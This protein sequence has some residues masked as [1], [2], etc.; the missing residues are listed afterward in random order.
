MYTNRQRRPAAARVAAATRCPR[1]HSRGFGC[2]PLKAPSAHGASALPA[3]PS[4]RRPEGVQQ[5]QEVGAVR[6]AHRPRGH[7]P[8][9]G[10]APPEEEEAEDAAA[11]RGEEHDAVPEGAREAQRGRPPAK[12]GAVGRHLLLAVEGDRV[13]PRSS[14]GPAADGDLVAEPRVPQPQRGHVLLVDAQDAVADGCRHLGERQGVRRLLDLRRRQ[15]QRV[16]D[17]VVAESLLPGRRLALVARRLG[18]RPQ[19]PPSELDREDE[20]G[21]PAEAEDAA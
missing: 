5:R 1:P 20:G 4:R 9:E 12:V 14:G 8:R 15:D 21:P 3:A 19:G 10:G 6:G 17:V 7:A 13:A 2:C 18:R 11:G 16:A